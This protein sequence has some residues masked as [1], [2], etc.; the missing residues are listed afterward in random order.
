MNL[1]Q[2]T[3]KNVIFCKFSPNFCLLGLFFVIFQFNVMDKN[4]ET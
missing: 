1:S 4:Y 3:Q 2:R